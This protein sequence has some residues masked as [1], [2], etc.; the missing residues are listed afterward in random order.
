MYKVCCKS[1]RYARCTHTSPRE[2]GKLCQ[3]TFVGATGIK[4]CDSQWIAQIHVLRSSV[5]A[6]HGISRLSMDCCT[7]HGSMVCAVT[8]MEFSN[9][10]F[11]PNI[12]TGLFCASPLGSFSSLSVVVQVGLQVPTPLAETFPKPGLLQVPCLT[13]GVCWHLLIAPD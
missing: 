1:V 8:S 4:T 2:I 10:C 5:C 6:I 12:Y 11:G 3:T 7:K 13:P 9:P